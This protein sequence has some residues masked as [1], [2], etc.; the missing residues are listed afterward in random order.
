ML[1]GSNKFPESPTLQSLT[2]C[3]PCSNPLRRIIHDLTQPALRFIIIFISPRVKEGISTYSRNRPKARRSDKESLHRTRSGSGL[4]FLSH[5]EVRNVTICS[6]INT[7]DHRR[8]CQ[9]P[10]KPCQH[11]MSYNAFA[12]AR[13]S[14]AK[15][16]SPQG[17]SCFMCVATRYSI[18]IWLTHTVRL[19]SPATGPLDVSRT[20]TISRNA[21]HRPSR[22]L[23]PT[24]LSPPTDS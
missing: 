11:S 22:F 5:P 20:F 1:L 18:P 6:N 14:W 12:T 4:Q 7:P 15:L 8:Y 17:K 19:L 21:F 2:P 3:S 24:N 9:P 23:Q 10:P 13:C 16:P